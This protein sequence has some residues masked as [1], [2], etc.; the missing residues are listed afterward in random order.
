MT[1]LDTLLDL[2]DNK[3]GCP[4]CVVSWNVCV[5]AETSWTVEEIAVSS[6]LP[7]IAIGTPVVGNVFVDDCCPFS[8]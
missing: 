8:D 4:V 2:V 6:L 1:M 3:L 7:E 5:D